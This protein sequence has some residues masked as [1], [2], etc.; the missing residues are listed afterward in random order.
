MKCS[1]LCFRGGKSCIKTLTKNNSGGL[2]YASNMK[3][4]S[5]AGGIHR[6]TS[7]NERCALSWMEVASRSIRAR[8]YDPPLL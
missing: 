5:E 6:P 4:A 7:T 1:S 8:T 2:V 3:K